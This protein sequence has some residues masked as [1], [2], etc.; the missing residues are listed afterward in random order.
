MLTLLSQN[1]VYMDDLEVEPAPPSVWRRFAGGVR[2]PGVGALAGVDDASALEL[3]DARMVRDTIFRDAAQHFLRQ[4][5][6]ALQ[7]FV[8]RATDEEIAM[9]SHTRTA[10][11]FMI[12]AKVAG[13]FD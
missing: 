12:V 4:F 5:D 2:G 6:L 10:Y 9:L 7:G 13:V 3:A 1:G 11:A 8:A